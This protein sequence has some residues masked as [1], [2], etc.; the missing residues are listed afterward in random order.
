MY[1][2]DISYKDGKPSTIKDFANIANLNRAIDK[3][4][5]ENDRNHNKVTYTICY[6]ENG[7]VTAVFFLREEMLAWAQTIARAG[8]Q[9]IG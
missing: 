7:R 2:I 3:L 6:K 1:R 4:G 5:L 9:V 8:F